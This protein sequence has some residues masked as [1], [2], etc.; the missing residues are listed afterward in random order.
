MIVPS[1]IKAIMYRLNLYI[2]ALFFVYIKK[3]CL[4]AIPEN[5]QKQRL[6]ALG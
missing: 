3:K 4:I 2:I 6:F 5:L 1:T